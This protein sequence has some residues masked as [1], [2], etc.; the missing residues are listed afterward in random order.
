L[1]GSL[2]KKSEGRGFDSRRDNR[3]LQFAYL[4]RRTM[5]LG[6]THPLTKPCTRKFSWGLGRSRRV[7]MTSPQ[8]VSR[9]SRQCGILNISQP[10]GLKRRVRAIDVL[11]VYH[12]RTSEET[13]LW[14]STACYVGRALL[15]YVG[16]VP[17]SQEPPP[18]PV[19]RIA[20]LFYM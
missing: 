4:S 15:F 8:S 9:L 17:T 20:L 6:L 14:A 2:S 12:V 18:R 19:T 10:Y 13:H 1:V 16:Y 5:A 11:Y 3:I 7:R